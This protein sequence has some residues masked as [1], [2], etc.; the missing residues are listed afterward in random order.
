[1]GFLAPKRN[2]LSDLDRHL[3][4]KDDYFTSLGKNIPLHEIV[5]NLGI[6]VEFESILFSFPSFIPFQPE[7][8]TKED[9]K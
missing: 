4:R 8:P 2:S 9:N 1:M 6:K 3:D 7:Q 5:V